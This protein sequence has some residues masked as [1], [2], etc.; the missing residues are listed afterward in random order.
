MTAPDLIATA[1][2]LRVHHAPTAEAL[3]AALRQCWQE[4][5][6]D[7][8]DFDLA[9]VPG[10]GFQR[11]LSQQL[12]GDADRAGICAGIEFCSLPALE[13][14]LAGDDPWQPQRLVWPLQRVALTGD[15]PTLAD[16]SRHLDASREPYSACLRIARHFEGYAT[17]R[18]AMLA[19]WGDGQDVAPDGSPL[20]EHAWQAVLWRRVAA[21]LGGTPA[22]ARAD[23]LAQLRRGPVAG[24]PE[25]IAV[26]AP[27]ALDP[28]RLDLLAAL[29]EHHQVDLLLLTP[30]P[31]RR[32]G[33]QLTQ[34]REDFRRPIGHPLNDALA[35]VADERALLLPPSP[36]E[37]EP[38][39]A[40][41][42]GWLQSDLRADGI[43]G[44]RAFDP[45]DDSVQLH[46]SHGPDRQVEVL[47][48]VLAGLLA[49]DPTLEPRDIVVVTP[50]LDAV[51]PLVTA[52]FMLP[53]GADAH[54]GHRFRVQLADRSVAQTNPM[55][56]LL[57][58]LLALPDSR[59]EASALLDLCAQPAI[60]A[61]FGFTDDR[62]DRL[63]ELVQ[64]SGI[65]WGL[66]ASHRARFGLGQYA[67]NTW[68]AGVQRM[69]LGVAL[70]ETDLVTARTVLPL[71]DIDS[72]DVE[73]VG[74]L[75][76]LIGRLSRLVSAFEEPATMAEWAARCRSGL[77]SLVS[78]GF[79][80]E[81]QLGDVW[82]GLARAAAAGDDTRIGRH[83]VL[84]VLT[85][86]FTDRPARG[87][88]GNGS[89]IV[90]GRNSLRHVP[91]R[92]VVL[93]GWDAEQYPRSERRHGDDLLGLEP[94]TG[95]PSA[96]LE[97]RQLLL[98]AIHA[99]RDKLVLVARGRSEATNE[100]VP[101]AAPIV[102][103][104]EAVDAT[105]GL[106][107]GKVSEA[108]TR[109]HPLQPFDPAYFDP[110]R[111]DLTSVDPLAYRGA[112][113][114]AR[115]ERG[116]RDR[117]RFEPLPEPDLSAGVGLDDLVDFFAHPARRLLKQRAGFTLAEPSELDDAVPLELG[118]LARWKV[119][120]R[121]LRQLGSGADPALV[122]RAEWLRGEVPPAELGRRAL[123]SVLGDADATLA[124]LPQEA[125]EP[126]QTR[127]V[128]LMATLPDGRPVSLAGRVVTRGGVLVQTEFSGLQP[129]HRLTAWLRLLA[130]TAATGSPA[131]AV[132]VGKGRAVAM[133]APDPT[134]SAALLGRYLALYALGLSRPLPALP[135]VGERLARLRRRSTEAE[136]PD[137]LARAL[138]KEWEWDSDDNW[139]AF[140]AWPEVLRLP[141]ASVALPADTAEP[142]LVGALAQLVWSPLLDCEEGR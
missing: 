103:L 87:A 65:R 137:Q 50:Q 93:L 16:L 35:A 47:R 105:A 11:W 128:A 81:W 78:L 95:D 17:H 53:G 75:A 58:Q 20:G 88:F 14:R 70:P 73:L 139:R 4:P 120:D 91:H 138:E 136:H 132:V 30:T 102:E 101:L 9:V 100:P 64:R 140:F 37:A 22:A 57:L 1:T 89:L 142:S 52:A 94:L 33:P 130:L 135:R 109:R 46:L 112:L 76:E 134:T 80:Q 34:P 6:A 67:Q 21:E 51:A 106:P 42:L 2:G 48:E 111:T 99:A 86:E 69:L 133:T 68:L 98:D 124:R 113:A 110:A 116:E 77:E 29:G 96:T 79:D 85:A 32:P 31:S 59:F 119:G 82:A 8:F 71:D 97:D 129:R 83:G 108:I 44:V 72:S 117:Y 18:P 74:G 54:P 15:D 122:T 27:P 84:R 107:D 12:A 131:R 61:R 66:S 24:L 5:P 26:V 90:C 63:V 7:V 56:S 23:L 10:P 127:D 39:P 28:G 36:A 114:A 38:G 92:V 60:A 55:V 121:V 141:A 19:A 62:H 45:A 118:G 43:A 123:T 25:R 40:T 41:L 126:P 104:L 125:A 49:D 3:V 13:R 115:T